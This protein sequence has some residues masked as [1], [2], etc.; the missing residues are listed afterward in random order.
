MYSSICAD[1]ESLGAYMY[2][3]EVL[4]IATAPK[5][6]VLKSACES[7]NVQ[8]LQKGLYSTLTKYLSSLKQIDS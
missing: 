8:I 1:L 5:L 6:T 2:P 4:T 7:F 3:E